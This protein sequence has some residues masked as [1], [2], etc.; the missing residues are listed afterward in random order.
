VLDVGARWWAAL[1]GST[2]LLA[3]A[4]ATIVGHDSVTTAV[5][6]VVAA[7]LAYGGTGLPL[8]QIKAKDVLLTFESPARA[9]DKSKPPM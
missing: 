3:A 9:K 6:V 1:L 5:L 2:L 4:Y 7:P 8:P